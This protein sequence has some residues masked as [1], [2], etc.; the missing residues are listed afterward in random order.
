VLKKHW[1]EIETE[2]ETLNEATEKILNKIHHQIN[3]EKFDSEQKQS[4]L[5]K[6]IY[7]YSKIAAV[8]LIPILIYAFYSNY[9]SSN[10]SN[11]LLPNQKMAQAKIISPLGARTYFTLPDGSSGW[12]NSG[13]TLKFPAQFSGNQ[14]D[15]ELIGEAWFNV[16]KN[17]DLPFVVNAAGIEVIALGT[18]FNVNAYPSDDFIDVTLESGKVIIKRKNQPKNKLLAE[19]NPGDQVIISKKVQKPVAETKVQTKNFTSWK[20]GKLIVRNEKMS[21]IA[22]KLERWYNVKI[23]IE[24]VE[25]ENYIY[26]ATFVD[27]TIEE[28]LK[29]LK[30][31]SPIEYTIK[32]R[33]VYEDGVL[34]KKEITIFLNN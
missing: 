16:V 33:K 13:S 2:Q 14:R 11:I 9:Q 24:D 8:L 4:L 1:D 6:A 5:K 12:L 28:V 17:P 23:T 21:E 20:Q 7:Y 32:G 3:L 30:L 22:T 10:G 31:T 26:R 25:I 34:E 19:L 27:E 18:K 15:L 29:Y